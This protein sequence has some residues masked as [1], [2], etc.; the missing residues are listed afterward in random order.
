MPTEAAPLPRSTS[1]IQSRRFTRSIQTTVSSCLATLSICGVANAEP[2]TLPPELGYDMGF[3]ETPRSL[4]IGGATRA[5]SNSIEALYLNPASMATARVYHFGAMAQ[6]W[7]QAKRQTYGAAAVDSL[8]NAQHI[9]GGI[10]ANWSAQD[11]DGINRD[12]FDLRFGL[13]APLSDRF[14]LGGTMHYLTLRQDGYPREDGLEPS[15]ASGGLDGSPIV[16]Q[17]TFDAGV[18]IKPTDE[19]SVA[20]VGTGLTDPGHG[21]LPFTFGGGAGFSTEDFSIE[22]DALG[23]FTTYDRT[24][25]RVMGGGELLLADSFPV[26]GGYRWDEGTST[27]AVSGGLG[28]VSP[29]FAVEASVRGVVAGPQ[30]L[31]V[32]FGFRYHLESAGLSGGGF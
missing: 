24:K 6:I 4:A 5:V 11:S 29:Q 22:V 9:A 2:S 21:F 1:M 3:M 18:T 26:R 25:M 13:A 27:Q 30:S 16:Q 28:Y 17:I 20:A 14:F 19:L 31:T 32:V 10:S 8:I 15:V 23:D 12:S 7:P